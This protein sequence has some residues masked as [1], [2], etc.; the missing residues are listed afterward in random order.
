MSLL[1]KRIEDKLVLV[2]SAGIKK[3][4]NKDAG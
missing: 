4:Y 3:A 2:A 1:S